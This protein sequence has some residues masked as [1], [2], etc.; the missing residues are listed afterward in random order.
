MGAQL[1]A[2]NGFS[3]ET[4]D[5]GITPTSVHYKN[6]YS[7]CCVASCDP[8]CIFRPVTQSLTCI[9]ELYPSAIFSLGRV[10]NRMANHSTP[11]SQTV[12]SS[13]LVEETSSLIYFKLH[14]CLLCGLLP[15]F[16]LF[17]IN[18]FLFC[19]LS[20]VSFCLICHAH[21]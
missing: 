18:F 12:I 15:G 17:F 8:A 5:E 2:C 19:F 3:K 9:E 20:G 13:L 11:F 21:T 16:F 4:R 6:I 10:S 7:H 14:I 1:K